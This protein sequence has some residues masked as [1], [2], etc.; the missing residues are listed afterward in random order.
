MQ[1]PAA[2]QQ[3]AVESVGA[4]RVGQA[5][6]LHAV[7]GPQRGVHRDPALPAQGRM[8]VEDGGPFL[9]D[10]PDG[11]GVGRVVERVEAGGKAVVGGLQKTLQVQHADVA[12]EGG[13][14]LLAPVED[15]PRCAQGVGSA[16]EVLT[17]VED[18][19]L[20]IADQEVGHV[21]VLRHRLEADVDGIDDLVHG[22]VDQ[23]G[24]DVDVSRV[25]AAG[26]RV[27]EALQTKLQ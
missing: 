8:D 12:V 21:Q 22:L 24:V 2:I 7:D 9:A 16:G 19:A 10:L 23:V 11:G 14:E 6:D 3:Q 1:A 15:M 25:P 5:Q 13:S 18:R 26:G 20:R 4:L 27:V 17:V